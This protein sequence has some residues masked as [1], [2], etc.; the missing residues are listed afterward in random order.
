MS[1]AHSL[2]VRV[3]LLDDPLV[4]M[5]LRLGGTKRDLARAAGPVTERVAREPKRT[6][7][8]PFDRW[9]RGPLA[10]DTREALRSLAGAGLGFDAR[11][12]DELWRAFE[13]GRAQWR[14]VWQLAVLGRW[15]GTTP[16]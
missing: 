13:R 4:E 6:F 12:V 11:A 1:M 9:L 3:P 14:P 7:T 16:G 5:A 15:V 10:G 2:E 8:L